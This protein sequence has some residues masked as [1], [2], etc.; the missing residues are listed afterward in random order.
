VDAA[1]FERDPGPCDEVDDRPGDEDLAGGRHGSADVDGDAGEVVGAWRA[2]A[3]VDPVAH[4]GTGRDAVADDRARTPD[5]GSGAVERRQQPA[6]ERL[7][8]A[9]AVA[10]DVLTHELEDEVPMAHGA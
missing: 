10:P 7:D 4:V 8:L 5:R 2:L 9:A 1:V 3:G 6:L